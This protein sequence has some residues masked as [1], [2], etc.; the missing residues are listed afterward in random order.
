M[1]IDTS[2][3]EPGVKE[4]HLCLYHHLGMGDAVECNGMVRHFAEKYDT[5]TV[6][7]KEIYYDAC[8]FMYRDTPKI[9][10]TNLPG[11]G[12][13]INASARSFIKGHKGDVLIPGYENF[14]KIEFK[15]KG[16]GPGEGFY[17]LAGIPWKYRNEKFYVERDLQKEEETFFHVGG[18]KPR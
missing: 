16:Y 6:F 5:V 9:K 1:K 15:K 17:H 2:Q 11:R 10:V 13:A 4:K 8:C 12:H 14:R 7:A 18:I 3:R